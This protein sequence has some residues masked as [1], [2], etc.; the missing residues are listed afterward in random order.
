[1]YLMLGQ[2]I[3]QDLQRRVSGGRQAL[4][5]VEHASALQAVTRSFCAIRRSAQGTHAALINPKCR[6]GSPTSGRPR[7]MHVIAQCVLVH[8][9]L[10]A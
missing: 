5:S 9:T 8:V 1:M 6:K 3:L 4:H 7:R 10:V 2:R